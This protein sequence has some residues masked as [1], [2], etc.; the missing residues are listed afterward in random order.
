MG[1]FDSTSCTA[2]TVRACSFRRALLLLGAALGLLACP[3]GAPPPAT[4]HVEPARSA[5]ESV[6]AAGSL[7]AVGAP[8]PRLAAPLDNSDDSLLSI[9]ETAC[10][11]AGTAADAAEPT[12][13]LGACID[14][15]AAAFFELA[16]RFTSREF[17]LPSQPAPTLHRLAAAGAAALDD[18]HPRLHA[19]VL[20]SLGALTA[21]EPQSQAPLV[22]SGWP[23]RVLTRLADQPT[24]L[25]RGR[26][27]FALGALYRAL[28][29]GPVAAESQAQ[30]AAGLADADR[31]VRRQALL[32]AVLTGD[33]A[34]E[35][36]IL[37]AVARE[38]GLPPPKTATREERLRALS[39]LRSPL[40]ATVAADLEPIL[41]PLVE[42]LLSLEQPAATAAADHLVE[43]TIN[44]S[45]LSATAYYL[46]AKV[47]DRR[48]DG[49]ALPALRRALA[50]GNL[51]AVF[52]AS[53]GDTATEL[54]PAFDRSEA[55]ARLRLLLSRRAERAVASDAP[56]LRAAQLDRRDAGRPQLASVQPA[57][58]ERQAAEVLRQHGPNSAAAREL[59]GVLFRS[60]PF[61]SEEYYSD[62]LHSFLDAG[63]RN[64]DLLD[65]LGLQLASDGASGPA[66][67]VG[68]VAVAGGAARDTAGRM[69]VTC[70]LCHSQ[71]DGEGR[72][73]DGLPSRTYDQG[74]LLAA[75]IDQPI[76][77][78]SQ[79]R[80]LDQ[81]LEYGPGR[82]D[83]TA[84][85]MHDPTEIPNLF[86]L[87]PGSA[88]RWNGDL[89]TL[90]LQVDR[91]LSLRSA[92]P[93]VVSLVA[94]YLRS[95]GPARSVHAAS[96]VSGTAAIGATVFQ[97]E[98]AR[99]HEPPL[100]SN[101]QVVPIERLDTERRRIA[102]V[103]PNSSP[104]YKVPSLLAI[105]RTAPYL[106]DGSVPTL[107]ALFDPQR[108]GGH[109]F[110]LDLPRP[111]RLSLLAFL[112]RL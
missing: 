100:Y 90:E 28:P 32:A 3:N 1:P 5:A 48:R 70:A 77:H 21:M 108:R 109:R 41:P 87:R 19:W 11:A 31:F 65:R 58:L 102:A 37:D 101:G 76:F 89:P 79:N 51:P 8:R 49:T 33:D 10:P 62:C 14:R 16:S 12:S 2:A 68:V 47:Y 36:P 88:V 93:A 103:L 80:N 110:G 46:R 29:T 97:R 66:T 107:E 83:S 60:Y 86:A 59:G 18:D 6:P 4:R 39:A 99:C 67:V 73:S 24:A 94:S 56:R 50:L 25:V 43:S 61:S 44:A 72:R 26:A 53:L 23:Q 106:H 17:G 7:S 82:N 105:G 112:R 38:L 9:A 84:D 91:N 63:G 92:P 78:K 74:V 27:L 64:H 111:E 75:C 20:S 98:C 34:L 104:G 30:I 81:L 22:G 42:L 85:G 54:T 57:A 13:S 52:V 15:R 95:L 71:V 45:P 35:L 69:G 55:A 40:P 96:A